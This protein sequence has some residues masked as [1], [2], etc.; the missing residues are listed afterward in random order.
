[1]TLSFHHLAVQG[2]SPSPKGDVRTVRVH[3]WDKRYSVPTSWRVAD[4]MGL[5][6]EQGYSVPRRYGKV[7]CTPANGGLGALERLGD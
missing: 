6:A 2:Y 3:F 4:K 5:Y 1:M 7:Q